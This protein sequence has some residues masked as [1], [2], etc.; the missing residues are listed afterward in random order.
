MQNSGLKPMLSESDSE[1]SPEFLDSAESV[2]STVSK[3]VAL[4]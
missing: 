1:K 3:V 4:P 2:G